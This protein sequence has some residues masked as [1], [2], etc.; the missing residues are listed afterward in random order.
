MRLPHPE[1]RLLV[2]A[3]G[4]AENGGRNQCP[5]FPQTFPDKHKDSAAHSIKTWP[6]PVPEEYCNLGTFR[7][8]PLEF[9]TKGH[10]FVGSQTHAYEPRLARLML[11][12]KDR[13]C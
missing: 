13:S 8:K 3:T 7:I 12:G 5:M 9:L 2:V 11:G 10:S 6:N 1:P 4:I